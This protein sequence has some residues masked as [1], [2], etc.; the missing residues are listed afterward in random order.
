MPNINKLRER[1]VALYG[2]EPADGAML[3]GIEKALGVSLPEDFREI[4]RFFRGGF[5]GGKSHH[6]IANSGP[7]NNI[8]EETVRLRKAIDLPTR[9]VVIA[10]PA[11]S[12]MVMETGDGN[13]RVIWC[14]A[15]DARN[16]TNI[17]TLHNPQIW[18]NYSTFFEYLVEEEE[19][20]R[21]N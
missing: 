14:D 2:N 16:L 20:E 18:A 10:E 4:A 13:S 19:G 9:F 7:A 8:V 6:A 11:E 3:V 15:V 12:L 1:Y 5:F 21:K 17:E